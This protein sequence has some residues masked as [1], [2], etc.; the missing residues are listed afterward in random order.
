A[1]AS[2]SCVLKCLREDL[3]TNLCGN[4]HV[5]PTAASALACKAYDHPYEGALSVVY[6]LS[7]QN[8][9]RGF[10][11]SSRSSYPQSD[12]LD[13]GWAAIALETQSTEQGRISSPLNCPPVAAFSFNPQEPTPGV[14]VHFNAAPSTDPHTYQLPYNWTFGDGFSAE[15]VNPNHTY[16]E[17]GDYTVTL[18]ALDSGT[19]PGQLYK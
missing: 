8:S 6:I 1:D 3:L 9:D 14:A 17:A 11:D 4:G 19:N 16:A 13:T 15:G 10:S 7:Q 5:Y 18:T 12:A 2:M